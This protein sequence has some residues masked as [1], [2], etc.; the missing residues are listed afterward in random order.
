MRYEPKI[1]EGYMYPILYITLR[2]I[3]SMY[4]D[5]LNTHMACGSITLN[6]VHYPSYMAI[7]EYNT[8][9]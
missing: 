3:K 7:F 9:T 1:M 5:L 8:N 2:N 4:I 6:P